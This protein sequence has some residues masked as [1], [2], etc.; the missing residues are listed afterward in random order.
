MDVVLNWLDLKIFDSTY[1]R[2]IPH[3]WGWTQDYWVRQYVSLFFILSL[4][5]YVIYFA[6]DSLSYLLLFNK[7]I[8]KSK[9]FLK[10]QELL[11]ISLS[12]TSIPIMAVPSALIFLAEIRGHARLYED[13]HSHGGWPYILFSV[14]FY[15]VFTDSLIYWIHRWLHHPLLYQTVHKP[16]HR[17]IVSTPFASHAFH[18][19]DGFLQSTPYHIFV[20]LFPL[21]K[22]L[23]IGLFL[24][25]NMWTVSIHDGAAYYGG[26]ILNGTGLHIIHHSQFTWNYGQYFTLWDRICGTHKLE[27]NQSQIKKAA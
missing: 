18:P 27:A 25:V 4:G 20:F 15:L 16:H 8:R 1:E 13:F 23:Y 24:F 11:E 12:V 21:N 17:W 7:E 5:G 26:K 10:N 9:H 6:M 3:E 22:Y 2:I 14:L 19:L